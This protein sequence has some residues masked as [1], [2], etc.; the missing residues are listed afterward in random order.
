MSHLPQALLREAI[1]HIDRADAEALLLHALGRDRAW[2]FANGRDPVEPAVAQAF[3]A[4]VARRA[5]GEPV[6]YLKGSR[7][8]WTLDLAV[9]P[10]TLIPRPETELLVELALER[11]DDTPGRR[12][13]DLG[14]G[15]GAIALALASERPR[16]LVF[17]TDASPAALEVARG[18]AQA[19]DLGRVE[20]REGSWWAPLAGERFDLV[21]SNPPYI[22]DDDP[23]LSQGDLRFEPATAL[24]SGADGLEDI[25]L[26]VA[27]APAH[28]RPGGWLLFEHGWDQGAAVAALLG[29]RGFVDVAT[30]Q[31]LEARDRVTLGRWPG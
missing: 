19:N 3:L 5:S 30:V 22:A 17:A 2:L 23:H 16:A 13:A 10:A 7:G 31:D 28:L 27:G 14:T 24:A 4:L 1:E 9:T 25:R 12:I 18:N 29:E 21:A 26:I 15:S 11:V 20:F 8:F 6:A